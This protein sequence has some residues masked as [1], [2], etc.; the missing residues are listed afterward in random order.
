MCKQVGDNGL[1]VLTDIN[2]AMLA[3]RPRRD[4]RRRAS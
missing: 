2:A 3:R 1:V 4:D